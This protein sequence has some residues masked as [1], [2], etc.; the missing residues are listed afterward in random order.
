MK[1]FVFSQATLELKKRLQS[2]DMHLLE[3]YPVY[4]KYLQVYIREYDSVVVRYRYILQKALKFRELDRVSLLDF[5][6]GTGILSFMA[7]LVGV[8]KVTYLDINPEMCEGVKIVAAAMNLPLAETVAGGYED[9]DRRKKYDV[10]LNYDVLE[11][12]YKPLDAFLALG[13]T[14]NPGGTILM[15]SGANWLNPVIL[16]FNTRRQLLWEKKGT[17]N[18][19]SRREARRKMIQEMIPDADNLEMLVKKTRGLRRDDIEKAVLFY[20][21]TGIQPVPPFWTDTCDPETGNWGEHSVNFF[22]LAKR[23]REHFDAVRTEPGYYPE[24]G[25]Q[26]SQ[27]DNASDDRIVSLIYPWMRFLMIKLAPLWNHL[28]RRLPGVCKYTI[29]PYYLVQV[30]KVV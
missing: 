8:G 11:H 24:S 9:L 21:R 6:G 17:P 19:I 5:G 15:A 12:L 14:L 26:Y 3:S 13:E 10:I 29:A 27:Y 4:R 28:I 23:L 7:L 25:G 20:N 30:K 22:K 16:F 18:M 1:E 2:V